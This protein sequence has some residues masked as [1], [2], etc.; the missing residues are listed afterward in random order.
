M[1]KRLGLS[2]SACFLATSLTAG[3]QRLTAEDCSFIE[4]YDRL[5]DYTFASD[6]AFMVHHAEHVEHNIYLEQPLQKR[7]LDIEISLVP[8]S[9]LEQVDALNIGIRDFYL[10]T[11]SFTPINITVR[12]FGDAN[13]EYGGVLAVF[14]IDGR[15]IASFSNYFLSQGWDST[16]RYM[17]RIV[18][19]GSTC[20]LTIWPF[21]K[22][23]EVTDMFVNAE[24]FNTPKAIASCMREEA[25]NSMG[26]RA[27]PQGD[28]SIF[29]D[30]LWRGEP[31]EIE[32]DFGYGYRDELMLKMLYRP[33]FENGQSY[34]ETQEDVAGIIRAE[35]AG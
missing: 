27:D 9:N 19:P 5:N 21:D 30:P 18:R 29:S 8:G 14:L 15:N 28:A 34:A 6:F 4:R 24:D 23:S 22:S 17:K 1:K 13:L 3:D 10:I 12:D 20:G 31:S 35:C 16:E 25:F 32:G 11:R 33:E 26:L 7:L 2:L